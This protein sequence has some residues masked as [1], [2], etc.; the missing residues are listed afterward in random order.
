MEINPVLKTLIYESIFNFPL[1][2]EEIWKFLISNKKISFEEFEAYL[3]SAHINYDK[4]TNLYGISDDKKL[5]LSRAERK[6]NSL[7]KEKVAS[8]AI[9][10]LSKIPTIELI[11]VSGSL[12]QFSAKKEDDVDL[13]LLVKKNTVWTTRLFCVI[14]LKLTGMYR[15]DR[16]FRDKICLNMIT[17]TY[18]FPVDRKDL[19]NAFEIAQMRPKFSRGDSYHAFI[20][21]NPWVK[22][23]LPNYTSFVEKEK[24]QIVRKNKPIIFLF[25]LLGYINFE[26]IAQILQLAYMRKRTNETVGRHLL[27]FHPRDF[28]SEVLIKYNSLLTRTRGH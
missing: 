5:Y 25:S 7:I 28:R 19:Y 21:A 17:D 8:R 10:N 9:K 27:A 3:K 15:S 12:A 22:E 11:A 1:Y 20:L 4:K 13:F 6:N 24:R 18:D 14:F 2:R 26:N 16:D 23:F